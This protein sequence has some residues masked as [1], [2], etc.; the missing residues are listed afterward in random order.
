M[1]KNYK[2][3]CIF[4]HSLKYLIYNEIKYLRFSFL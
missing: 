3:L 2:H 4:N 1:N